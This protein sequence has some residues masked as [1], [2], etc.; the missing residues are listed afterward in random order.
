MIETERDSGFS[1]KGGYYQGHR[2]YDCANERSYKFVIEVVE[3][4]NM[5]DGKIKAVPWPEVNSF[6][7]PRGWIW[8]PKLFMCGEKLMKVISRQNPEYNTSKSM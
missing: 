4:M 3:K 2:I 5:K 6:R 8:V 7:Q 1:W